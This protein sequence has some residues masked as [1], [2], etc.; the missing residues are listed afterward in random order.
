VPRVERRAHVSWEGSSA[1][2]TGQITADTGA[3]TSLPYTEPSRVGAP[4]GYTSPEELLA[5]AHA[6]CFA[7]SLAAELTRVKAPPARLDVTSTV[8]LDEVPGRG[9]LVVESQLRVRARA[10]VDPETFER[11]VAAADEGCTMSSLVK[12]SARV[13]IEADLEGA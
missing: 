4:E 10:A 11:V 2:G 3:F 7:M 1:K 13:T 8:V 12:G 6:G 9:H 5:A